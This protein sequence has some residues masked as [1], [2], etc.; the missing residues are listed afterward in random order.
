MIELATV[1]DHV[2]EL[3]GYTVRE[4]KANEQEMA[5]EG[6]LPI[7]T[8]GYGPILSN[9]PES[10][11]TYDIYNL[12]GE[13]LVQSFYI[14][15]VCKNAD[16]RSVFVTMLKTLTGWNPTTPEAIHTSFTYVNGVPIGMNNTTFWFQTEWKINF[17]TNTLLQ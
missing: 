14:K 10:P 2:T 13:D 8:I 17:P 3:T 16:F 1:I 12:N 15:Y 11:I 4:A 9:N 7:I 5:E 6:N